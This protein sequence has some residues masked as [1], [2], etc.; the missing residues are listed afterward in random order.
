[1]QPSHQAVSIGHTFPR[2]INGSACWRHQPNNLGVLPWVLAYREE[3]SHK[4][5]LPSFFPQA[6]LPDI[7][8]S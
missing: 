6:P 2:P 7:K 4:L 1:M 5:Q 8:F 3:A